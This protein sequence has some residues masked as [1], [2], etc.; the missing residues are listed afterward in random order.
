MD[1]GVDLPS[2]FLFSHPELPGAFDDLLSSSSAASCSHTHTCNPPG[3]S[4]AMHTHTCLHTHTQVYAAGSDD[5][6]ASRDDPARPRR[7]LGN[8]EAVRKYR[9]KK[10]AHAAFLE[11]E[12]KKLRAANQ[13]LL[14]RLQGHA[15]LEAEVVRLRSLLFDVRGKIDA[16][17]GAFPFQKQCCVGSVV[18]TDPNLCFNA[19]SDEVGGVWEEE[20]SGQAGAACRF[21]DDGDGGASREIGVLEAVRS[22]DVVELCFPS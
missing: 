22:M 15:T 3:P 17:V 19:N 16:E 13:Q 18:C 5:E 6:E 10:K 8:R 20:S 21:D 9:E 1:D 11:E 14:R 4:A 2:Q 7:P 12:V